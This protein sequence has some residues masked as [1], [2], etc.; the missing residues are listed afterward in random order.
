MSDNRK[1]IFLV[2]DDITNLTV[3]KNVLA[4]YYDV[5]T[6]NSGARLLKMLE[7]NIPDLILLDVNM[8]EMN[9]Y[10]IIEIIKGKEETKSIPVIFLTAKIDSDSEL[11]GLTLGAIDYITKPFPPK[12]LLKHIEVHLLVES[13][14]KELINF[15][16][17]LQKMVQ[18]KTQSIA[19]L[20]SAILKT[21]A[22]LVEYRDDVTG[23]HIDRTHRYL[24]ILLGALIKRGLF[25]NEISS[26]NVT[27]VLESSQL[28]DVGK[29]MIRDNILLKPGKLTVE[30][31]D[32]MKNHT[33]YGE[34]IIDKM[35]NSTK[36]WG[37]LEHAR[38]FA[39]SHHEKWDGSGYPRKLK[40]EEIP[41]QGRMMAIVDVYDALV[42]ERSYKKAFM[43][44]EAVDIITKGKSS[45]FDPALVDVFIEI[46]SDF[47]KI[48]KG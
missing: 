41:L 20:Q 40:G 23:E 3:G 46:A 10:E 14:K 12:L 31:F 43:H 19:E 48:N 5:F 1:V 45:H 8:P 42:S 27:L 6:M 34:K 2:D 35:K 44:E 17:N 4:E 13:Q 9:G 38:I 36:D 33:L 7:K 30:E 32:E 26:W 28:H 24:G 15:N 11:K 29:I 22:E 25:A 39:G 37:F 16:S 47:K 18:A 21:M